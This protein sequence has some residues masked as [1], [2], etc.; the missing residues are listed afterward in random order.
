MR[1][2]KNVKVPRAYR[3]TT[4][5]VTVKRIDVGRGAGR[6]RA[7]AT[8]M[9]NA[10]LRFLVVAVIVAGGWLGWQAYQLVV[11]A[12]VFQIAGVDMKGVKQVSEAE[13]K[14]I[15]GVFS[16]RN[17]FRV[18][19][20][21]AV[22]RARA[23][24]WVRDVRIY[25]RLPNRITMAFV[26]RVPVAQLE[27]GTGRYLM[28]SEGV[29]I[30]RMAPEKALAWPLPVVAVNDSRVS[31][32]ERVNSEGMAEALT[33]LAEIAAR[34]GW[35]LADI[36]IKAG[37]PETLSVVYAEHEFKIGTGNYAEKL[38]RLAEI[39]ADVKQRGLEIAYVDLRPERQ[40][41]AMVKT[42]T[43]KGQGSKV[44]RGR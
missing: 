43:V 4:N 31:P 32:G 6:S 23:N 34:G 44:K 38:R 26:E 2:Y 28:D 9:R 37:S 3:S 19:L 1:D 20:E 29:I 42:E 5:R 35:Q 30:E 24:P 36:T 15:A 14:E 18:D 33:L 25:R 16:G 13:L 39:M 21:T 22:R 10:A 41:A 8:E 40:A 7:S 11:H 12:E 27:T 17:I